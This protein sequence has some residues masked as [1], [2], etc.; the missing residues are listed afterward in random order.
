ME[1]TAEESLNELEKEISTCKMRLWPKLFGDYKVESNDKSQDTNEVLDNEKKIEEEIT[2]DNLLLKYDDE[3]PDEA[4]E[5]ENIEDDA[6]SDEWNEIGK[7]LKP[8]NLSDIRAT[9]KSRK[10][11]L[12]G[13]IF[14]ALKSF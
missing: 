9:E 3:T 12:K 2:A 1:K 6:R 7:D 8:L 5:N 13:K 10:S 4:I 11:S 14:K